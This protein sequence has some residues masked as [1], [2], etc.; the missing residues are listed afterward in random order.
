MQRIDAVSRALDAYANPE[1]VLDTLLIEWPRDRSGRG[2][3]NDEDHRQ[4][5]DATV[6]GV[7]QGVGFRW[8]VVR[9]ASEL[10][11]TGWTANEADGSVRVLAEGPSVA[12]DQPRAALERRSAGCPCSVGRKPPG[13]QRPAS[14]LRSRVRSGAHRGD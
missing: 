11:L 4:R 5:L 10:G 7:V 2:M 12:L 13:L 9:N 6:R 1:L 8:F 14:S 3:T